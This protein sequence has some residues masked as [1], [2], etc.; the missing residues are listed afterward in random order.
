MAQ[1]VEFWVVGVPQNAGPGA[2]LTLLDVLATDDEAVET[3]GKLA[4]DIVGRVVVFQRFKMFD[5]QMAVT[6]SESEVP[7]KGTKG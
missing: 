4:S 1:P 7:V 3:V 2:T 6:T 5:R